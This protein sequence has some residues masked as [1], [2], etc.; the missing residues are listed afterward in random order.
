MTTEHFKT[1]L[2]QHDIAICKW[3]TAMDSNE[4]IA[5]IATKHGVFWLKKAA[6]ARGV[7]RYH[8]L[9]FFSWMMR[10]PLLK[11][12]PQPG[13]NL[14]IANEVNRINQLAEAGVMVPEIL[15]HDESWLLI[16]DVGQSIIK[17][18]K[19]KHTEQT[20]RQALFKTCLDAIKAL[21]L[22]NQYLSQGFIRNM[23][24]DETSG[25][26]AFIDFEDDPM[27][28]MNLAQAQARDVLLLVN[29]TARFF[30]EDAEFF[31]N[32]I[33]QFITGH[34]PEMI[35]VLRTTA[36]RLQWLTR[37]PL[38]SLFGHDYQKLK[39]GILAL[40]DL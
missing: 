32:S 26:I 28:V 29:S 6:P 3:R 4:R 9:N 8:A 12:V 37:I 22:N 15:A 5:K 25:T 23:L 2:E 30:V 40:K 1:I 17:T 11:A 14:A 21:H 7:F 16:K 35:E 24:L 31:N 19:Q 18:L 13:G 34:D 10:L 33:K 39:T 27:D 36:N 38:Q 20:T